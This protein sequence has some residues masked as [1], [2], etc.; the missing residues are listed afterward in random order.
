VPSSPAAYVPLH[1]DAI[2]RYA[3]TKVNVAGDHEC[4]CSNQKHNLLDTFAS[5]LMLLTS[6]PAATGSRFL[7]RPNSLSQ[8]SFNL[9]IHIEQAW[10]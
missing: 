6:I 10:W 7:R 2:I 3:L 1:R 8:A 5:V 4:Q 9:S